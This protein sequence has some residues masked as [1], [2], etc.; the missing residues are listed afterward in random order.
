MVVDVVRPTLV[1]SGAGSRSSSGVDD[2]TGS[3]EDLDLL[4]CGH[5]VEVDKESEDRS[6]FHDVND[7]NFP[8]LD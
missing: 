5:V 2:R 3:D 8:F 4:F 1:R 7:R 6:F